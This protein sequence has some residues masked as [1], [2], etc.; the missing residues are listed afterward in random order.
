[1]EASIALLIAA[2]TGP[3]APMVLLGV[4]LV[5][6]GFIGWKW[7]DKHGSSI[8]TNFQKVTDNIAKLSETVSELKEEL[9]RT[10][11]QSE[12]KM[13]DHERRI[14]RLEENV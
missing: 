4:I 11:L 8:A 10:S 1:M 2:P 9:I 13:N 14:E 6:Q 5:G 12:M 7:V 3:G